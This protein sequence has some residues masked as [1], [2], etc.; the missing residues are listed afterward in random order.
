M[1]KKSKIHWPGPRYK[2]ATGRR[3]ASPLPPVRPA[4]LPGPGTP[5]RPVPELGPQLP[6]PP[7]ELVPGPPGRGRLAYGRADYRTLPRGPYDSRQPLPWDTHVYPAAP[8]PPALPASAEAERRACEWLKRKLWPPKDKPITDPGR[9]LPAGLDVAPMLAAGVDAG[10][11]MRDPRAAGLIGP[12]PLELL[13]AYLDAAGIRYF[14]A[15]E[16]TAHKWRHGAGRVVAGASSWWFV[17]DL[18]GIDYL[19]KGPHQVLPRHVVPD[20]QL[21]PSILPVLRILDRFRYWLNEPVTS[22]SSYRH[23]LYN[24][25]IEG[26]KTSR[27]MRFEAVDFYYPVEEIKGRLF[28]DLFVDWFEHIYRG[29]DDGVGRYDGFIHLDIASGRRGTDRLLNWDYRSK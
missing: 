9:Q 22:I 16:L 3:P 15:K 6:A 29:N 19:P 24:A 17:Y 12:T 13:D 10:A 28:V 20:P 5:A 8:T 7:V 25:Q 21:W 4:P 11:M 1:S 2:E 27:H 23:P 14:S 18:L 26:S